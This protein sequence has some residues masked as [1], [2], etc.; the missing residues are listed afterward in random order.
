MKWIYKV[1]P[2]DNLIADKGDHDI[3][4]S[5]DASNKRKTYMASSF[6]DNLNKLG[7]DGW[8]MIS[9]FAEF[10]IFKKSAG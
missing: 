6:E 1:E 5:K 10:A 7:Q 2:V 9:T 3:A 8:E 4:V